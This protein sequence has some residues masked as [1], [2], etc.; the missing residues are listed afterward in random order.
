MVSLRDPSGAHFCGGSLIAPSV[1]L[2]AAHCVNTTVSSRKFP[3]VGRGALAGAPAGACRQ[4]QPVQPRLKPS[5]PSPPHTHTAFAAPPQVHLGRYYLSSGAFE[6]RHTVK[7]VQH[8]QYD[9]VAHANDIALL[10]LDAPS[11]KAP[12]RLASGGAVAGGWKREG[13]LK[14]ERKGRWEREP[15]ARPRLSV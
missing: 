2:T 14:K 7:T 15:L 8:G 12:I 11:T 1:V 10:F 5:L 4:L 6:E 3:T 13:G 9:A